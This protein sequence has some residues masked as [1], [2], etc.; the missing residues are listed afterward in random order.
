MQHN[1]DELAKQLKR[2]A[3]FRVCLSCGTTPHLH[4]QKGAEPFTFYCLQ[5][6]F[7]V[8]PHGSMQAAVTDWHRANLANNEHIAEVWAMRY[9]RT[10]VYH[11]V[12]AKIDAQNEVA[13]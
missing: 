2:F 11:I 7:H 6:G 13:A 4:L 8:G 12:Q 1:K 10:G 3:P 5:C 9:E